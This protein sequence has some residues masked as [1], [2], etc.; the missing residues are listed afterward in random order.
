MIDIPVGIVV[1]KIARSDM[2]IEY[3]FNPDVSNSAEPYL[4]MS[5]WHRKLVK[6]HLEQVLE[7]INHYTPGMRKIEL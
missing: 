2:W 5:S 3:Q 4:S 6:L 7:N 1:V